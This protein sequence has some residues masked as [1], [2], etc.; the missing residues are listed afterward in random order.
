MALRA[1]FWGGFAG[2]ALLLGLIGPF[3][4]YESLPLPAR[5]LYWTVMALA[6]FW[7]GFV[8][9]L[10]VASFADNRGA[11]PLISLGLGGL[12][13]SL[14]VSAIIG[15]IDSVVFKQPFDA[16]FWHILPYAM[17]IALVIGVLCEIL[18][19][20]SVPAVR[21]DPPQEVP[22]WTGHLPP[23]LGR[24]LI[25]LQAQDHYVLA[26]TPKGQAL[27]RASISEATQALGGF[28]LRVHRSWWVAR[29][30]IDRLDNRK[31]R[32]LLILRDGTCVPV[33]RSYRRSVRD[34]LTRPL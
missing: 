29:E 25:C 28:G 14:P 32:A 21:T 16:V 34:A 18:E 26:K 2:V 31:G 6:T 33:G 17:V 7:P 19:T 4:T 20:Q 27:V 23:E 3:G 13:A 22:A 11:P 30:A 5:L 12:A 24:D 10:C 8:T 9:S 1:R 15:G